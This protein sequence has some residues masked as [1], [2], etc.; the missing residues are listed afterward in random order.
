MIFEKPS[1]RTRVSF[2]VGIN[3]LGGNAILLVP[4]Q[5]Q[6][7]RGET[8]ADTAQVLS[9]YTDV[10]MIRCFKHEFLTEFAQHSLSPVIN[11]LTDTSH[12]CQILADIMTYEEHRN[13]IAGKRVAWLGDCNNV[14]YSWIHAAEKLDFTLQISTPA[15]LKPDETLFNKNV[16]WI[17]DPKEA[18]KG[19]DLVTT[20]TWFS[21]GD[22][23]TEEKR[24]LL[25]D[26][27]VN[28]ELLS[29]ADKDVLFM[30]CLPAHRDEE[31]TS[32]VID[33]P[34]SVIFDEAENRL[35]IQKSIMIWCLQL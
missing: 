13:N 32:A 6:L 33:G 3:Q 24:A 28:E 7:G 29:L 19:V 2:E 8:T 26:Y 12:P 18:V 9:R 34:H 20:D 15:A 30:H 14:M 11:G 27:Q 1:T 25:C 21:M 23:D 5:T 31:V 22:K 4:D 35:H 17:E 16:S 10:I